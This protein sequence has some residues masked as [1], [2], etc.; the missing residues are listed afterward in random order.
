MAVGGLA[1]ADYNLQTITDHLAT[2]NRVK[3]VTYEVKYQTTRKRRDCGHTAYAEYLA[4]LI[5]LK[6]VHFHV[7]FAPFKQYNHRDSG[8]NRRADTVG[9]MHYQLLLHRALRFYGGEYKLRIRPDDGDCTKKLQD[10]QEAL[11]FEAIHKHGYDVKPDCIDSIEPRESLKEPLLQLL[12]VTLGAFTALR[13]ERHLS[14]T[15][16]PPKTALALLAHKINGSPNLL[17]NS[18]AAVRHLSIWNVVPEYRKR[19]EARHAGLCP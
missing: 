6:K 19:T 8:P 2:I 5:N 9:K 7:R 3:K 16:S 14:P 18:G 4:E 17:E 13:N 10:Q 11:L 12:D 1:V 15:Y